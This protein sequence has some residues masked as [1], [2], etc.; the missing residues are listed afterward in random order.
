MMPFEKFEHLAGGQY[1]YE[2][3]DLR[4]HFNQ[5]RSDELARFVIECILQ[6]LVEDEDIIAEAC[7]IGGDHNE[8]RI[9]NL[10]KEGENIHWFRTKDGQLTLL[11][12]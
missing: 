12:N 4:R 1:I 3:Y 2:L 5:L 7:A 6:G 10:L 11:R 9:V 8:P